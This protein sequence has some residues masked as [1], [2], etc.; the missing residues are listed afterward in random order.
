MNGLSKS[1]L[2][3]EIARKRAERSFYEFVKQAWHVVEPGHEFVDGRHIRIIC[4][5]L[6][7]LTPNDTSGAESEIINIPPRHMKSL[8]TCV[9]W[10][11]WMW[12]P[13]NLPH[14]QW[15]FGSYSL[16]LAIRDNI[17]RR[18]LIESPWYQQRWGDRFALSSD[19][20]QKTRFENDHNGV[21]LLTSPDSGTTGEGGDIIVIDDPHNVADATSA[22]ERQNVLDWYDQSISTRPNNLKRAVKVIIGQRIHEEDLCG[23]LLARGGWT[24]L[25]LPA[26]FEPEHPHLCADDWRTEEGDLLWPERIGPAELAQLKR[27]LGSY[28]TAGQLQQRP[29]PAEGNLVKKEWLRWY[30]V[31]PANINRWVQSWDLPFGKSATS[32]YAV[33]QV[34]AIVGADAYLVDQVRGRWDFPEQLAQL[35]RLSERY[36]EATR[37]LI[38]SAANGKALIDTLRPQIAG[39]VPVIVA[40]DKTTRLQATLPLFEAGNVHIKQGAHWADEWVT[41]LTTF[42]GAPNDDQVDATSQALSSELLRPVYNPRVDAV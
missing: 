32:D 39:L 37:K 7:R 9:F 24:H 8:L 23:H 31:L 35:K 38:E 14:I 6:Q 17:K 26:E 41:E 11:V 36:P 18:R 5:H 3:E 40:K 22:A 16:Q 15:M 33:G 2:R 28:G 4:D 29:A 34:W 25:C 19:Q 27:D 10:P 30:T 1:Q 12:G 20:N 42:P 21:S 13:A